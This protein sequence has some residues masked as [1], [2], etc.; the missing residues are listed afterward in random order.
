MIARLE[1]ECILGAVLRRV[2]RIEPAG[3][4]RWRPVNTLRTLDVLPLTLVR[5]QARAVP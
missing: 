1:A 3:P 4:A 2:E 5:A